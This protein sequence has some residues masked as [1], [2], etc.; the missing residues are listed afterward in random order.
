MAF[1]NLRWTHTPKDL[2]KPTIDLSAD[3]AERFQEGFESQ[4]L[5]AVIW[6]TNTLLGVPALKAQTST[7]ACDMGNAEDESIVT[8]ECVWQPSYVMKFRDDGATS[9]ETRLIGHVEFLAGRPGALTE[10]SEMKNTSEYGSL[11]CVL[12]ERGFQRL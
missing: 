10:A 2:L 6:F 4:T 9:F 12:G 8:D 5:N 1:A 7:V 3:Q 11:R